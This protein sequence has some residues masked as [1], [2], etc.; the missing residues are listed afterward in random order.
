MIQIFVSLF[1]GCAV[2]AAG[3]Y[4][5]ISHDIRTCFQFIQISVSHF[6]FDAVFDCF[7]FSFC[8]LDNSFPFIHQFDLS[9]N[10]FFSHKS[11]SF[12]VGCLF[13]LSDIIID[14]ISC[15]FNSRYTRICVHIFVQY[16]HL[17]SCIYSDRMRTIG[18]ECLYAITV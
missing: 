15:I 16:V 6:G 10:F 9:D 7:D 13:V 12:A 1:E 5:F 17:K 18:K 2:E 4:C 14:E 3:C 11:F 8:F